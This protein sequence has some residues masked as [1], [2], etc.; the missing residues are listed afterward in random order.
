MPSDEKPQK[1]MLDAAIPEVRSRAAEFARMQ[2]PQ[3]AEKMLQ[4][5]LGVSESSAERILARK[6]SNRL[7][8]L[9][10]A[11]WGWPFASFVLEPLCGS[12]D[13]GALLRRLDALD[14]KADE[15]EEAAQ[16]ARQEARELRLEILAGGRPDV[17]G[18]GAGGGGERLGAAGQALLD[19]GAETRRPVAPDSASSRRR[20]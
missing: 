4:Q 1:M 3:H 13:R 10:M 14:A 12:V 7:L 11:R 5:H 2:W 6:A 17:P 20:A 15:A 19:G 18:R 9:M 16:Q 8:S